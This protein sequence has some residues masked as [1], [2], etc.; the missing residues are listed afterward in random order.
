M[1]FQLRWFRYV[2]ATLVLSTLAI[3]A[4]AQQPSGGGGIGVGVKA[5]AT[6]STLN[7]TNVSDVFATRAGFIGGV[8]LGGNRPGILGVGVD[9]LYERTGARDAGGTGKIDMDYIDVPVY[10]RINLGTQSKQGISAYGIAGVD[11]SFLMKA[12]LSATSSDVTS[13]FE[14]PDYGA[15]FGFGVEITRLVIE[16][17]YT[18]GLSNI[19]KDKSAEV[20]SRRFAFM[21]GLRFN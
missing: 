6:F 19:L 17:R 10:A 2:L 16:A 15:V 21:V 13:S 4:L 18:E 5:G 20:K 3:P 14:R 8:F 7:Q 11:L 12:S 1:R 9:V